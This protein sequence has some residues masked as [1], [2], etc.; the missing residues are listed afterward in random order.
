MVD[1]I[2]RIQDNK[3]MNTKSFW[4]KVYHSK[5]LNPLFASISWM[6]L[7]YAAALLNLLP[8]IAD[9]SLFHVDGLS[10]LDVLSVGASDMGFHPYKVALL[11]LVLGLLGIIKTKQFG[12]LLTFLPGLVVLLG[13][14][15]PSLAFSHPFAFSLLLSISSKAAFLFFAIRGKTRSI[16]VVFFVGLL[17]FIIGWKQV[18][19]FMF[20]LVLTRFLVLALQQNYEVLAEARAKQLIW[21]F[22]RAA[23]LWSPI[24]LFAVPEWFVSKM[25]KQVASDIVYENTFV[26]RHNLRTSMP[27]EKLMT[28]SVS[29][30]VEELPIGRYPRSNISVRQNAVNSSL[31][32]VKALA[33]SG[34]YRN[35]PDE[36]ADFEKN[37]RLR[38]EAQLGRPLDRTD[39]FLLQHIK[40]YL[41]KIAIR[42]RLV[43]RNA[44][45][46]DIELSIYHRLLKEKAAANASLDR[47]QD[48]L[49]VQ[50]A[51]Q[52]AQA[53][54]AVAELIN[55]SADLK[56]RAM[57]LASHEVASFKQDVQETVDRYELKAHDAVD[58][59]N[60]ACRREIN[61]TPSRARRA[62]EKT[63][64]RQITDI[65]DAFWPDD[66]GLL[67]AKC[68]AGNCVK[69]ELIRIYAEKR[70]DGVGAAQAAGEQ[71]ALAMNGHV[72]RFS[73]SAKQ[74]TSTAL[75]DAQAD[76]VGAADLAYAKSDAAAR[77]ALVAA[78]TALESNAAELT[79]RMD[80]VH[81]A[82]SAANDSIRIAIDHQVEAVNEA[83]K[84]A[85]VAF[86]F[87]VKAFDWFSAMVL[88]FVVVNSFLYVFSRVAFSRDTDL[89]VTLDRDNAYRG[90]ERIQ[91]CGTE[92]VVPPGNTE[93]YYVSRKFEPTGRAPKL[94]IPHWTTA[95]YGRL[96]ANCFFMNEVD[97]RPSESEP[98]NFRSVAGAE[99]LEWT[100]DVDDEVVINYNNLVA[101]T[102]HVKLS[103]LISVR[104]TSVLMGRFFFHVAKGPGK[105]ILLSKGQPIVADGKSAV[106]SLSIDRLLSWHKNT[107]FSVK[108]ELNL[109]DIYFSSLYLE[110]HDAHSVIIDTDDSRYEKKVG[111]LRFVKRFLLP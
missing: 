88:Y 83:T 42:K 27:M 51:L 82:I 16:S 85:I 20:L 76:I 46:M 35:Y 68:K 108:S 61:K 49:D 74:Q 111:L 25:A 11:A 78:T 96:R 54:A 34:D 98:V 106:R 102:E 94:V 72:N 75:H 79:Q 28:Y 4:S 59:F 53:E 13:W 63:F 31:M 64:P 101:L 104:L 100:L 41:E 55:E 39:F 6:Q 62:F 14:L 44:M 80:S 58:S 95:V 50:A 97:V 2:S 60:A 90:S 32:I 24:L 38:V 93:A 1:P 19:L 33:D 81:A 26:E 107:K 17:L 109:V 9:N 71:A 37:Y 57:N 89:F 66:C 43:G 30:T 67:E 65:D 92:Y 48:S 69:E 45:E 36:V 3:A 99:F 110:R 52:K 73:A 40:F 86:Q 77:K 29:D 7:V 22:L 10:Y 8:S 105:V 70:S 15:D 5:T 12:W 21:L 47:A 23:L 87:A 56:V 91:S 103:T 18:I 84:E